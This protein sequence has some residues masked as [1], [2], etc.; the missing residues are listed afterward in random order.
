MIQYKY[1]TFWPRFWA[2]LI[3]GLIFI[4]VGFFS[5]WLFGLELN[6]VINFIYY[7][8]I[9]TLSYYAYTVYMH[10]R[11]GKTLGKMALKIKVTKVSG[12]PFTFKGAF[13]R[14]IVIIVAAI[15]MLIIE[16]DPILNGVNPF[17]ASSSSQAFQLL[18]WIQLAWFLIEFVTMLTNNKRR[19]V[20]DFIA[21]SVVTRL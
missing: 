8:V 16:A 5:E 11:F 2:G 21:G 6:G 4:P 1:K 3:D 15:S 12:E 20:H 19:A 7:A 17:L 18:I 9:H 13:Y 10:G 14:D